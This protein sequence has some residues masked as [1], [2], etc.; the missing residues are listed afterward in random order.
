MLLNVLSY[1][2]YF[3][4]FWSPKQ[5]EQVVWFFNENIVHLQEGQEKDTAC[6]CSLDFDDK[7]QGRSFK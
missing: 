1:Y 3:I 5:L 2:V 7:E 4:V 6:V